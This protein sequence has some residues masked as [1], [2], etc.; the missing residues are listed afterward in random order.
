MVSPLPAVSTTLLRSELLVKVFSAASAFTV[1]RTNDSK[2]R[3]GSDNSFIF[4]FIFG[5][6][7]RY[8]HDWYVVTDK[9]LQFLLN[10]YII[11]TFG[12]QA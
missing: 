6:S 2:N 5:L 8:H 12:I 10:K 11:Q 7:P 4:D 3:M 1:V 9:F